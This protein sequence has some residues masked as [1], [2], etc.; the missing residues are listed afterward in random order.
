MEYFTESNHLLSDPP[1]L[2]QQFNADGYLFFRDTLPQL[3]V[4]SNAWGANVTWF[5]VFISW[6]IKSLILRYGGLKIDRKAAPLFMGL[7]LCD[8]LTGCI[9]SIIGTLFRTP[10]YSFWVY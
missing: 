5:P 1:A 9:W 2:R 7:I 10:T 4:L 6:V 8:F 3:E